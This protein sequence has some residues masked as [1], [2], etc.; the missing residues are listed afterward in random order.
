MTLAVRRDL[1]ELRSG[2]AKWLGRPIGA[3]ERPAPGWSCE[4]LVVEGDLVVRLPPLG[5]GIFPVYDLA[6]QTAVQETVHSCG[7]PVASPARF[8]PDPTFLGAPFVAMPF[9]AGPIPSEPTPADAWL[10]GLADAS[11]VRTVW[12]SFV[13]TVSAIH[14][15]PTADLGLRSGLEDELAFWSEYLAWA[16]DGAPPRDL[17]T[18]LA[19]CCAHRPSH[20]P[21]PGLLWGDVR[22]GNVVFDVRRCVPKA[23]LDWD[24]ASAGPAEMD[25]AWFLALDRLQTDLTGMNL[26]GFGTR[27][28]TV[29]TAERRMGRALAHLEWY[30][31]LALVRA[32]AISTRIAVLFERAGQESMFRIGHDP[33]LAAA[34]SRIAAR[35]DPKSNRTS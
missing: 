33:A 11:K 4:T 19:W 35:D 31:V 21:P 25:V 22:L 26:K 34:L 6:Q 7:V 27:E 3:I 1:D 32:S 9:V 15:T 29:A 16:C 10:V 5:D 28:E 14:A 17:T 23:V 12:L 20:E 8:E 2:L 24:M 18:A 30:E 13:E